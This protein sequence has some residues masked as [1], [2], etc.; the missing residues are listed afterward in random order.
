M[1]K[2]MYNFTAGFVEPISPQTLSK[3]INFE[4]W[5]RRQHKK[6]EDKSH[7]GGVHVTRRRGCVKR[8]STGWSLTV[9]DTI[10]CEVSWIAESTWFVQLSS[11]QAL[12]ERFLSNCRI[13]VRAFIFYIVCTLAL[14][15]LKHNFFLP[16]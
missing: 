13:F 4:C 8:W 3:L 5:A 16:L 9:G 1:I 15:H 10:L 12:L 7:R 6:N 2:P 11:S 14:A